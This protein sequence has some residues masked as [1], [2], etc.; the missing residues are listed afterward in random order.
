M[1]N[2]E[3]ISDTN[4]LDELREIFTTFFGSRDVWEVVN[5]YGNT[6][7]GKKSEE[8]LAAERDL[9]ELES[10]NK[11]FKEYLEG[12]YVS[13]QFNGENKKL[14]AVQ[15][16]M[17]LKKVCDGKY[18]EKDLIFIRAVEDFSSGFAFTKDSFCIGGDLLD[19]QTRKFPVVP[20]EKI[21]SVEFGGFSSDWANK[22]A[23]NI[24]IKFKREQE[25]YSEDIFFNVDNIFN[26]YSTRI[27]TEKILWQI[28]KFLDFVK[29]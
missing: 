14:T 2:L 1:A 11:G 20:Y 23:P 15:K 22:K 6:V 17:F 28:G 25:N 24:F 9:K 26:K 18:S 29:P 5:R 13:E 16:K 10:F 12:F 7:I 19:F 21:I 4:E 8:M 3:K 27:I